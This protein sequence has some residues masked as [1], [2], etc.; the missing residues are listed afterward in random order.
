MRNVAKTIH[1]RGNRSSF[2]FFEFDNE[3]RRLFVDFCSLVVSCSFKLS[4]SLSLG[5]LFVLILIFAFCLDGF[6]AP[7]CLISE[8]IARKMSLDSKSKEIGK[9][10]SSEKVVDRI[11]FYCDVAQIVPIRIN[12]HAK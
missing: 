11:A 10:M 2:C 6:F 4:S 5:S 1:V 12:V 8:F 3:M 7:L 9:L